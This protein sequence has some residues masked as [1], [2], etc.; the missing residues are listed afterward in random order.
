MSK[1]PHS[2]DFKPGNEHGKPTRFQPG[3]S[4]NPG[5]KP[6]GARNR[7]TSA[8]LKALAED[9]EKHGKASIE[10]LRKKNVGRYIAVVASLVPR[11]ITGE[12]GAPIIIQLSPIDQ[13]L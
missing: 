4:G 5:G 7:V 1:A 13:R 6:V 12:D 9:F 3:Q 10:R 8:F 2:G 11:E